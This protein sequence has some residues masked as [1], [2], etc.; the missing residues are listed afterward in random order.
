MRDASAALAASAAEVESGNAPKTSAAIRSAPFS[1][2]SS[3]AV[4]HAITLGSNTSIRDAST[5][6]SA[7]KIQR[8]THCA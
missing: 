3:G 6:T 5:A 4:S 2:A 8:T 1:C 7:L